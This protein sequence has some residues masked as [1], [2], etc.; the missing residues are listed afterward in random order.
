MPPVENTRTAKVWTA[1]RRMVSMSSAA[2]DGEFHVWPSSVNSEAQPLQSLPASNVCRLVSK[3]FKDS[4]GSAPDTWWPPD[5]QNVSQGRCGR[6]AS[7]QASRQV[8]REGSPGQLVQTP[9]RCNWC[10][11]ASHSALHPAVFFFYKRQHSAKCRLSVC[12]TRNLCSAGVCHWK[13]TSAS[14]EPDLKVTLLLR[15]SAFS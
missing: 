15:Q 6:Q 4:A 12:R 8:G 1:L 2:T 5:L 11:A 9:R 13:C 10:T 14:V 3:T 7:K